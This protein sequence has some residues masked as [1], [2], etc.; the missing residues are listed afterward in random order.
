MYVHRKPSSL[1]KR[2]SVKC[3]SRRQ[4]LKQAPQ[5]LNAPASSAREPLIYL[6]HEMHV[7]AHTC[8]ERWAHIPTP[9]DNTGAERGGLTHRLRAIITQGAERGGLTRRLR[10]IITQ[11]AE[12]GLTHRLRAIITQGAERGG[13]THRLRAIITRVPREV[14]SHTDSG[15]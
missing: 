13:L 6:Q 2:N 12:R 7:S 5:L 14:G 9:G 15:R 11:G 10:A 4:A 3:S 8:R 1:P